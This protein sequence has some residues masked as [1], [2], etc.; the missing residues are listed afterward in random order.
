MGFGVGMSGAGSFSLS[1]ALNKLLETN[2]S[3]KECMEIAA[4]AEIHCGTGL[5]T[6]MTQQYFGFMIGEEP[7]PSKTAE[8]IPCEEDTVVC[9]FMQPIET[10]KIIRDAEWKKKINQIGLQCMKEI[11]KDKTIKKFIEL[12][13]HFTLE[14]GLASSQLVEIMQIVPQASMAMLGQTLFAVVKSNEANEI[15]NIFD[16]FANTVKIVKLGTKAAS[17]I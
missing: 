8:I 4:K 7:Y 14:T 9:A 1:L 3:Y 12:S 16:K 2:F 10:G 5:G 11:V 15:K 13:R 6:V 17:I